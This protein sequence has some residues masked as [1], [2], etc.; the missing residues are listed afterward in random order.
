MA[1][2]VVQGHGKVLDE[3]TYRSRAVRRFSTRSSAAQETSPD[4]IFSTRGGRSTSVFYEAYRI[5]G[6]DPAKM[7]IAS[8]TTAKRSRGDASRAAEGHITAAPF[9][10]LLPRRRAAFR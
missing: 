3:L 7:P 4:V 5:A 10:E 8:L 9:F 1:D 2:F 6:F